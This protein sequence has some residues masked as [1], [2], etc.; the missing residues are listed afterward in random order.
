VAGAGTYR[1][2]RGGTAHTCAIDVE[3]PV[4][5]WGDNSVGQLGNGARTS[6]LL[7]TP[8]RLPRGAV[9]V[10]LAT[11]AYH[12][13]ALLND[14]RVM[15]WGAN[16]NG[17]LGIL[18]DPVSVEPRE[19]PGVRASAIGAGDAH[20]CAALRSGAVRCWGLDT[21]GQLG[22]GERT[23]GAPGRLT[24]IPGREDVRAVVAGAGH[25]CALTRGGWVWCWGGAH[26]GTSPHVRRVGR[27]PYVAITAAGDGSC[28]VPFGRVAECWTSVATGLWRSRLMER[29]SHGRSTP[30]DV[31]LSG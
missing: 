5:C 14:D 2:V 16:G 28:A 24:V 25:S 22:T 12:S 29:R 13:C 8:V 21:S 26:A 6:Q 18:G 31:G 7:P 27:G 11:G 9:A 1:I 15:C 23:D 4:R 17:Q 3:G 10:A 19:V 30:R 20:T